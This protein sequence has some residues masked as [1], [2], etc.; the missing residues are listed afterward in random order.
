MKNR[1]VFPIIFFLLVILIYV[2]NITAIPNKVILFKNEKL[3]LGNIAGITVDVKNDQRYTAL[4]TVTNIDDEKIAKDFTVQLKLFNF[5]PVKEVSVN[6]IPSTTVIPVGTTVGL[7]LYTDGVLVVG[8]SEINGQRPY[9]KTGIEE[10]DMIISL[11]E[12]IITCTADLIE[13]V[14][15][16]NGAQ[17]SVKYIRDGKEYQ[18]EIIPAKSS[19]NEYK[20]GLW[21]RDAAA[22]VGTVTYYEPSTGNFAALGHGILD[23]DT[24][25]LINIANGEVVTANILSIQK[26]VKGNPGEIRGAIFNGTTIGQV[27][28]NTNLGIY[29]RINN[30]AKLNIST[31]QELEVA[32]RDEISLGKAEIIC[33]LENG[34]RSNY[35]I[36]IKKIYQGNVEDNKSMLIEVTDERLLE[37]TGGI[38]QGMSGSP[39]IQNGKFI[40]AITHVLVNNPKEGYAVFADLMIKE[41]RS[42]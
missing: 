6:V 34:V 11:N 2:T 19:E 15:N 25:K 8:M 21:V 3:N 29:G 16:S 5:I 7:K 18:T 13:K 20:L 22:G 12:E 40:G 23:I 32:T 30:I 17:I 31:E 26:G 10:G 36:E 27:S 14:N 42:I 9:E 24:G 41:M 35:E 33:S 28:K 39:I 4:Q 1:K 37:K 38:I